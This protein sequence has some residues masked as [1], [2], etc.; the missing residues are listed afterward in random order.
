MNVLAIETSGDVSRL[1]VVGS[2]G[3]LAELAFRHRMELS[4]RIALEVGEVLRLARLDVAGVEGVAVSTGPG[5]FT[6]LRI[7]V[8]F[9]KSFAFARGIPVAG[10]GTLGAI[11]SEQPVP[12]P[13]V[14]CAVISAS[15]TEVFSA[16]YRWRAERPEPEWEESLEPVSELATR[17]E[18]FGLDVVL[19]GNAGVHRALLSTALGPRLLLAPEGGGPTA[20]TIGRL[21]REIILAGQAPP[22]H[23]LAPRYLRPSAAEARRREAACRQP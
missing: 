4:S 2:G 19:A 15:A 10:V 16:L 6:G 17:L 12:A 11:A 23:A 14:V 8:T 5:S 9:A 22:V 3:L 20:A 18:R 21:G 1:A 13:A 7:G